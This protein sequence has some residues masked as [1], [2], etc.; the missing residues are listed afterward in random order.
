MWRELKLP[1]T[2]STH[3]LEDHTLN[4]MSSIECIVGKTEDHI[5]RSYQIGKRLERKYQCY[6]TQSQ[7]S[8]IKFQVLLSNPIVKMKSEEIK[9][10]TKRNM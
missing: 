8:Q 6:F 5:E 1:V 4:Q 3:L 2:V 7:T 10:E 9:E